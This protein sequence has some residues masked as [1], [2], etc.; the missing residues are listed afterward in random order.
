ME[1]KKQG[2]RRNCIEVQQNDGKK[3]IEG[4]S[5]HWR[6]EESNRSPLSSQPSGRVGTLA[7]VAGQ[8]LQELTAEWATSN[9]PPEHRGSINYIVDLHPSC[10]RTSGWG[11]A[12]PSEHSPSPIAHSHYMQSI[13]ILDWLGL[14]LQPSTSLEVF[15]LPKTAEL[16]GQLVLSLS[17]SY[18]YHFYTRQ[19]G[20]R[21]GHP[22]IWHFIYGESL[23]STSLLH[24]GLI[25]TF[26]GSFNSLPPHTKSA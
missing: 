3:R 26:P 16:P 11:T 5:H 4:N 9:I 24:S 25:G 10:P 20:T 2:A 7:L 18:R 6:K 21:V 14:S 22:P 13:A 17:S 1:N 19:V 8:A 12:S 23:P 15:F